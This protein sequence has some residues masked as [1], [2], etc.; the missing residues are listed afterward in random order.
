M[1]VLIVISHIREGGI[2]IVSKIILDLL[3]LDTAG[4]DHLI[5]VCDALVV[6][7]KND[8]QHILRDFYFQR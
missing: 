5:A 4:L 1:I 7:P 8:V 6:G 3:E 2:I